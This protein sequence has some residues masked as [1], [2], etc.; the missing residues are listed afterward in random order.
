MIEILYTN[1]DET[2][3]SETNCINMD[4][5]TTVIK[6]LCISVICINKV[7]Q[8][9]GF[10]VNWLSHSEGNQIRNGI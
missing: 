10:K 4:I 8:E 3:T 9:I 7:F 6:Y 2:T 1:D 5:L